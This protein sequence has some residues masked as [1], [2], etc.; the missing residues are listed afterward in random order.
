MGS[1]PGYLLKNFLLYPFFTAWLIFNDWL[2]V[3]NK[4]LATPVERIV[5]HK[6]KTGISHPRIY[7]TIIYNNYEFKTNLTP[8]VHIFLCNYKKI[9]GFTNAKVVMSVNYS[10]LNVSTRTVGRTT[11]SSVK[12]LTIFFRVFLKRFFPFYIWVFASLELYVL[13]KKI[14][15]MTY[16]TS[17]MQPICFTFDLWKQSPSKKSPAKGSFSDTESEIFYSFLYINFY[18]YFL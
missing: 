8:L 11:L 4:N 2:W 3:A 13:H 14:W 16:L 6:C 12:N 5:R 7:L 15:F 10:Y 1:N 17:W 18:N 9:C